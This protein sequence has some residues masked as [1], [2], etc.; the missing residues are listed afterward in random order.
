[1]T[2]D[3]SDILARLKRTLPR[4]FG[5]APT[6]VL[7]ALLAAPAWALSFVYS[8]YA[9]AKQQT[10]IAT[11]TDGWLDLISGD[12]FGTS[13]L[14]K[15]NQTDVSYRASILAALLRPKATR[16][17]M[18]TVLTQL[19]GRAPIVFEPSLVTDTGAMNEPLSNGYCGVARMGSIA[20]PLNALIIAFRNV[21]GGLGG[22]AYCNAPTRSAM[23]APTSLSYLNSLSLQTSVASD[24]D[25]YAAVE[26][27]RPAATVMGVEIKN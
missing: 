5:A 3:Q 22:A 15:T 13:L 19:T 9:Y 10:R 23:S 24:A 20:V 1:M 27:T 7:D 4:W 25:I 8:L 18:I 12:F 14:R 6:P 11:A 16:Q 17:A 26:A 2:G 21:A